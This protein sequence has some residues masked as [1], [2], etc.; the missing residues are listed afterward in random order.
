MRAREAR[1]CAIL[2]LLLGA[3]HLA[4]AYDPGGRCEP[5]SG[6][7]GLCDP[8]P[9]LIY[10]NA[11]FGQTQAAE[12]VQSLLRFTPL[13]SADCAARRHRVPLRLQLPAV[14]QPELHGR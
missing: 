14:R 4:R 1:L 11:T 13:V 7:P 2:C 10:V 5:Y 8:P 12:N 9:A 3:L 6:P